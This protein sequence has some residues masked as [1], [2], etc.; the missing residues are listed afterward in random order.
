MVLVMDRSDQDVT[1]ITS[2]LEKAGFGVFRSMEKAGI[3]KFCGTADEKVAL[4]LIDTST[5][6]IQMSD[7]LEQ[8]R[9]INPRIRFLLMSGPNESA[10]IGNWSAAGN[11]CGH[12]RRPF[13][14]AH[15]LGSVL[16]AA[17]APLART[18]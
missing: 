13:R 8:V 18:A 12:L 2:L 14:R 7:L 3:L 1:L 6:G 10:L 11:V 4:V 9:A 15:F 17:S 16:E 5:P